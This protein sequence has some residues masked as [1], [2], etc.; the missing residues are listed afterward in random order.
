MT[1]PGD[2]AKMVEVILLA[3][4]SAPHVRAALESMTAV[5]LHAIVGLLY[6]AAHQDAVSLKHDKRVARILGRSLQHDVV[7]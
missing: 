1:R 7:S 4:P 6:R 2:K 3:Y 5:Q